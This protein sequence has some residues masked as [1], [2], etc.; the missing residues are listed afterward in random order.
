MPIVVEQPR[1]LN[2]AISA[3]SN[4]TGL[5]LVSLVDLL[6][7]PP[8]QPKLP[9]VLSNSLLAMEATMKM[10]SQV[11]GPIRQL[12]NDLSAATQALE[13]NIELDQ[14]ASMLGRTSCHR[15]WV[16]LA[17]DL[18]AVPMELLEIIGI[19]MARAYLS[20]GVFSPT[21]AMDLQVLVNK[22]ICDELTQDDKDWL[23]K[24]V[25]R[26][27]KRASD[28]FA[29][30]EKGLDSTTAGFNARVTA[31]LMAQSSSL[32]VDERQAAGRI[33]E[34]TEHEERY[35]CAELRKRVGAGDEAA[36]QACLA[37]CIGITFE[38]SLGVPFF[39]GESSPTAIWV[40]PANGYIYADLERVFSGL[41]KNNTD[42]HVPTTLLLPRPLPA[43]VAEATRQACASNPGLENI[44]S[45][46]GSK[47]SF[48]RS[49]VPGASVDGA[50]RSSVARLIASRGGTALRAGLPRDAAAY[51]TLSLWLITKS[52]HH[53][54][55]KTRE[56][57]WRACDMVYTAMG[58]GN[59]VP[60]PNQNGV[61]F[62]SHLTP[63]AEWVSEV[64]NASASTAAALRPGRRYGLKALIR[65]HNAFVS[66]V[67]L[68]MRIL[69][70]GRNS[71]LFSYSA[72]QWQAKHAFCQVGDKLVGPTLGL[73]PLPIPAT[74]SI[75]IELWFVHLAVLA[76]RLMKLGFSASHPTLVYIKKI[77]SGEPIPLL[78]SLS[79]DGSAEQ[80]A[81]RDVFIGA[82]KDLNGDFS[83]HFLPKLL[84]NQGVPFEQTQSWL[85]H[86]ADGVTASSI[87]CAVVQ[88]VWLSKV[89]SA[90]DRIALDLNLLPIHGLAKEI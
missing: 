72:D 76:R 17:S 78:F 58:W 82:A 86:H 42:R 22:G 52:D 18:G 6:A 16:L 48:S 2:P 35:I 3:L 43:F 53:Y 29:D 59:A 32:R 33:Q 57:I 60:D 1:L 55:T 5:A 26:H 73:T 40:D 71:K 50:I 89:A 69:L 19:E 4:A 11:A 39:R 12:M 83:R 36:L 80:L 62:G 65:H 88:Q 20:Q 7:A 30:R 63:E 74:L 27:A 31:S 28:V 77:S 23:I 37:R 21:I 47:Q 13:G 54:L 49:V 64:I 34:M 56:E 14:P 70:G 8:D 75:Q 68:L 61:N 24:S 41:G 84:G 25:V 10:Q 90:L 44:G 81:K 85:R 15:A 46:N 9:R 51:A 67:G 38:L 79:E 66:Y 87:T 45:L